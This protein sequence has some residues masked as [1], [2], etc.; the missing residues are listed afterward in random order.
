MTCLLLKYEFMVFWL[1]FLTVLWG[2]PVFQSSGFWVCSFTISSSFHDFCSWHEII[3]VEKIKTRVCD[4]INYSKSVQWSL[5]W[6]VLFAWHR[7]VLKTD[8]SAPRNVFFLAYMLWNYTHK[9]NDRSI[10]HCGAAG[11]VKV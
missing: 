8:G 7:F 1:F 6:G 10:K 2:D 5:C 4:K 3:Y 11:R 9:T